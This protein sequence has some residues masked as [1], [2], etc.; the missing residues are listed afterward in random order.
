MEAIDDSAMK[1]SFKDNYA[2]GDFHSL[3][4]S[5]ENSDFPTLYSKSYEEK[6]INGRKAVIVHRENGN[7]DLMF[8]RVIFLYFEEEG[9]CYKVILEMI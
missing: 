1:Y 4:G 6:E 8:N 3:F 9:L 5:R 2:M 7:K